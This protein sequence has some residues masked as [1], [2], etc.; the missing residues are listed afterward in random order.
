MLKVHDHLKGYTGDQAEE[1]SPGATWAFVKRAGSGHD[2]L[3]SGPSFGALPRATR[4]R[5]QGTL[6]IFH[7][8]CE[9]NSRRP[10]Q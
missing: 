3:G 6:T 7:W 10:P 8:N 4:V 2:K 9:F 5:T 1:K